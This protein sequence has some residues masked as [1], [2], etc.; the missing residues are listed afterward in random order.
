M[1]PLYVPNVVVFY[2]QGM[3]DYKMK[4]LLI[5]FFNHLADPGYG[6]IKEPSSTSPSRL[7]SQCKYPPVYMYMYMY[8]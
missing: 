7:Y 3:E 2:N 5:N 8:M 4:Y 1:H 6:I